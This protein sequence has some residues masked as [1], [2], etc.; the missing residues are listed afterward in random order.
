M[1]SC[2]DITAL[3]TRLADG[4]ETVLSR[5]TPV[6]YDELR[7]LAAHYMRRERSDHTLQTTALVH[8]AY[9]RLIEQRQANWRNRA[10][11]FGVAAQLMRRILV[12][13]ARNRVREKRGGEQQRVSLEDAILVSPDTLEQVLVV[14]E[15]LDRLEKMDSRQSRIVELKFFA[16]LS[17]EETA[18]SLGTSPRT[19]EREWALARAWLHMQFQE[20][21]GSTPTN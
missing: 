4:D 20:Q 16:G 2:P 19:V 6:V 18:E 13:H 10:H 9:L 17:T 8:E 1:D 3:L 15:A 14:D 21:R 7:R 5:L 11:F 12:D